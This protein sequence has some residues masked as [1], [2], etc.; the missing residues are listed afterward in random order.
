MDNERLA[1]LGNSMA[2]GFGIAGVILLV[3]RRPFTVMFLILGLIVFTSYVRRDEA[4]ARLPEFAATVTANLNS[5]DS[6]YAQVTVHNGSKARIYRHYLAC[7]Y[8][9]G[10]TVYSF[11][12]TPR[13]GYIAPGETVTWTGPV[14]GG[15]VDAAYRRVDLSVI[16]CEPK[17][18]VEPMDI[19]GSYLAHAKVDEMNMRII[20]RGGSGPE[21]I[22]VQGRLTNTSD[23]TIKSVDVT[24]Y[25]NGLSGAVV[26]R[27]DSR[28]VELGLEP[29]GSK[30]FERRVPLWAA[31][32]A[33]FCRIS[34][35]SQ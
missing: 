17:F 7:S 13:F 28:T 15:Y 26:Y 2:I 22:A 9:T 8:P 34:A 29:G 5:Y 6:N 4:Y 1:Q 33:R 16:S 30:K 32:G 19:P 12:T 11:E 31:T 25:S 23:K 20:P 21:V 3:I 14:I 10:E 35:I 18:M 27:M 24:C